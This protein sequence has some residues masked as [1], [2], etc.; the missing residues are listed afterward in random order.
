MKALTLHQPYASLISLG[1]KQYATHSWRTIYQGKLAIH[2]SARPIKTPGFLIWIDAIKLALDQG[3]INDQSQ[4]P[5]FNQLP[6]GAVVAIS[7]LADCR[8]I[9]PDFSFPC[10][11]AQHKGCRFAV[12]QQT[13][14]ELA[15][16]SWETD[17][18]ASLL[19]NVVALPKPIPAK[20]GQRLWECKINELEANNVNFTRNFR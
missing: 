9:I 13:P 10:D 18:Y 14:L 12:S 19:K 1:L 17:T 6:L 20:G 5:E 7:S 16:G 11:T 8:M 4:L 3:L 2:A 15:V